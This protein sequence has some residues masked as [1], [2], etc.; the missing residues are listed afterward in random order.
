[1]KLAFVLFAASAFAGTP[2]RLS[3]SS[4]ELHALFDSEWERQ[5]KE[6]PVRA[7]RLGD[8]RYGDRWADL[9]PEAFGRRHARAVELL[10]RLDGFDVAAFS[11]EDRDHY[12]IFR[13]RVVDETERYRFGLHLLP[14]SQR[15]GVQTLDYLTEILE[16]ETVEDYEDWIARLRSFPVLVD[17]TIALMREGVR[18]GIVHPQVVVR[19][20]PEQIDA[21]IVSNPE[22]S[23]F[24]K[25]F[26]RFPA[27]IPEA[28]RLRLRGEAA[29]AIAAGVVPSFKK[30]RDYFIDRYMSAGPRKIGVWQFPE[31][32]EA[33]A[34][35]ARSHTTTG[36]TP[37]AIHALGKAEVKRIRGEM[38]RAMRAAGHRRSIKSFMEFLRTD[39]RFIYR[40]PG[41]LLAGY[42][43]IAKRIDPEVVKLFGRL[44]RAPY[45]VVPIPDHIAPHSTTAYY[46][47]PSADGRRPGL[48]YVNLYKPETRPKYEMEV[49]TVHEAVPGHHLQIALGLELTGLPNFRRFGGISAFVEGWGLY[50]ESLGEELGLYRDPYSKFGQLTYEMWRAV[51]LVVDTGIHHYGWSRERAIKY[52][53]DNVAKTEQ[54]IVNEVDRYATMPGQALAYKI[55][56]LK[57]KELR[58]RA[59]KEL[60][61]KF[62]VRRFH[63]AVL[64]RGAVTL[65]VL[66][67]GIDAWIAA[68]KNR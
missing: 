37:E 51:R 22:D 43:E 23:L 42:R 25:P 2:E 21:Q 41:D 64:S 44:P 30:L 39:P 17:Q 40:N 14:V 20:V 24:Y 31:G 52:F 38:K 7:S 12:R 58:A 26:G 67:S 4:A 3:T 55:G 6:D 63:D 19:G 13:K 57:I 61:E 29:R 16:F 8:R 47:G 65:G 45:G 15:G 53:R 66:E 27:G 46:R 60:E 10:E 33:Y 11:S 48:Y 5:M 59:E 9:S 35:L 54:D 36:M 34:F 62:D 68:E 32:R 49:L 18:R 1:V 50:A 28:E 56:E